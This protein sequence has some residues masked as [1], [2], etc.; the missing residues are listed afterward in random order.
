MPLVALANQEL[1]ADWLLPAS[2]VS[3]PGL[4]HDGYGNLCSCGFF[5]FEDPWIALCMLTEPSKFGWKSS[6][7]LLYLL[8]LIAAAPTEFGAR[9]QDT[10]RLLAPWASHW[11]LW[12]KACLDRPSPTVVDKNFL[13]SKYVAEWDQLCLWLR[14]VK[15]GPFCLF[16]LIYCTLCIM[17][18]AEIEFIFHLTTAVL[19]NAIKPSLPSKHLYIYIY[20]N[21]FWN[22][23]V[24]VPKCSKF[25]EK[26]TF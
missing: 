12:S 7:K 1:Q 23:G 11:C 4:L 22:W 8:C 2:R 15:C 6:T 13:S 14:M 10:E 18:V 20:Q 9:V 19:S 5:L 3:L 21:I 17:N 24:L 16:C 26:Q 25:E